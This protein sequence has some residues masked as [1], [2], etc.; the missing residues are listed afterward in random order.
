MKCL[1]TNQKAELKLG[2]FPC[3]L[4]CFLKHKTEIM[5]LK[6]KKKVYSHN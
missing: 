2:V 4:L 3:P 1:L 6:K 5:T